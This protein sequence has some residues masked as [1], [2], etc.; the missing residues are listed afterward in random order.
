MKPTYLLM[1]VLMAVPVAS[2]AR[3]AAPAVSLDPQHREL[4][5]LAGA[6]TVRQSFW[7]TPGAAP[8]IDEGTADF[9]MVLNQRHLRQSLRIAD[10]T[11]FEGLGYI[12]YDNVSG[13]FF[14]TWMDVNF[15][16]LIVAR[17]G[18]D[19]AAKAY[20]FHGSMTTQTP[21]GHEIPVKEV[22]TIIDPEHFKY[23]YFETHE[24]QET[25]TVKIEYSRA[26]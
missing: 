23:E 12:G 22:M 1:A 20:V 16:G 15:P 7:T 25:L 2:A 21:S 3:P 17:G 13:Q 6:W 19:E 5:R 26:G 8:K 4:A 24:G 11:N 14:S 10:G 18:F 9:A